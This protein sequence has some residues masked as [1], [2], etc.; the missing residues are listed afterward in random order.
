M[1][2]PRCEPGKNG[3][4]IWTHTTSLHCV[5]SWIAFHNHCLDTNPKKLSLLKHFPPT[6]YTILKIG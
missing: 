2:E 3:F 1:A 6:Y 5:S 4:R